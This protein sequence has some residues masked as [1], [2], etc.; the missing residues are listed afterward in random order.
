M[1]KRKTGYREEWEKDFNW[2]TKCKENINNAYCIICKW[3]SKIDNS[4]FAQVR[5][6]SGTDG[7][8]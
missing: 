6:H 1:S 2:L 7:I 4:G 8:K 3:S 5:A